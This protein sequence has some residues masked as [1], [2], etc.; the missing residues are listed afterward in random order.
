MGLSGF[1]AAAGPKAPYVSAQTG[2]RQP[3]LALTWTTLVADAWGFFRG[4][5][6]AA[7]PKAPYVSAQTGPRQPV[8]ALTWTTLVADAWSFRSFARL[9][10]P[11]VHTSAPKLVHVSP[12]GR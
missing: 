1:G 5:G 6:A 8:L 12:S 2:P 3:V 9:R 11:K 10:G 7:G 4:F